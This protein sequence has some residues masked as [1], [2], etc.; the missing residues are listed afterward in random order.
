MLLTAIGFE[1]AAEGEG[2]L[3]RSSPT[4]VSHDP[5]EKRSGGYSLRFT[6]STFGDFY[7]WMSLPLPGSLSEFY[8]QFAYLVTTVQTNTRGILAWR[9]GSTRLGGIKLNTSNRLELW[10]GNFANK[11]A[12]GSTALEVNKWYV[13][14][15]HVKIADTEGALTL[16]VDFLEDANFIGD[17]KPGAEADID[18]FLHGNSYNNY[19]FLDD[20]IVHDVSGSVNNS[21]PNGAKVVLLRP[22]ADGSRLQ[23]TPQPSGDHYPTI[24]EAPPSGSDYLQTSAEDQVDEFSL[25]DLPAEALSVKAVI[26]QAWALKGSAISPTRLALGLKLG[27]TDYFSPDLELGTSQGC[28]PYIFNERPGGGNFSVAEVNAAKLLL[29]SRA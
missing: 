7:H 12:E 1:W 26:P 10:T 23:W 13:I 11:V 24:D 4:Y 29:K 28:V 21:W 15:V 20:L 6:G 22:D 16:R 19:S 3:Q 18:N 27:E 25:G 8:Y 5:S 17:T 14:E 9:K 2:G